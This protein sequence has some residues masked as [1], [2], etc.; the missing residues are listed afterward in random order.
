MHIK[1]KKIIIIIIFSNLSK[2]R[3]NNK[4]HVTIGRNDMT[5][6]EESKMK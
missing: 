5:I 1:H 6:P 2:I 3:N 4:I